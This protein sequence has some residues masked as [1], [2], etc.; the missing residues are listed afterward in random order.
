MKAS[1]NFDMLACAFEAAFL[2]DDG[3]QHKI[4]GTCPVVNSSKTPLGRKLNSKR[5]HR[6]CRGTVKSRNGEIDPQ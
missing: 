4:M 1:S 5:C 6:I 2:K 3:V